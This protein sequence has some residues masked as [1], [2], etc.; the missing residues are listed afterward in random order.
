MREE[1]AGPDD[2]RGIALHNIPQ[3]RFYEYLEG[4]GPSREGWTARPM[5]IPAAGWRPPRVPL[6]GRKLLPESY[7]GVEA[8]QASSPD[9]GR[10]VWVPALDFF[11]VVRVMGRQTRTYSHIVLGEPPADLFVPPSAAQV[12]RISSP[13]DIVQRPDLRR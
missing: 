12:R 8:Y 13:G 4:L 6:A 3:A 5:E 11:A 2:Y 9:G 10:T 1:L 7:E